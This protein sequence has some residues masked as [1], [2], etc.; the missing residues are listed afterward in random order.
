M[1]T[2]LWDQMDP[3]GG[4]PIQQPKQKKQLMLNAKI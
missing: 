4:R 3:S 2:Q 1:S